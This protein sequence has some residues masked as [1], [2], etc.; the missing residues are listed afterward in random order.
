MACRTKI[1]VILVRGEKSEEPYSITYSLLYQALA[2]G[3]GPKDMDREF[4]IF[5]RYIQIVAAVWRKLQ[6]RDG[7]FE[8]ML[9]SAGGLTRFFPGRGFLPAQLGSPARSWRLFCNFAGVLCCIFMP[10]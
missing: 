7:Q 1:L 5:L 9:L 2:E 10:S 3:D 4:E 8:I 6:V